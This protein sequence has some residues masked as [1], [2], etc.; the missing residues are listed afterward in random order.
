[1][2][3]LFFDPEITTPKRQNI[4]QLKDEIT[5]ENEVE[6]LKLVDQYQLQGKLPCECR[7]C[8]LDV[9]AIALNTLPS[10]Y[11]VAIHKDLYITPEQ[12]AAHR[13]AVE[14]AVLAACEK[15]KARPHH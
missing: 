12:Q 3:E 13:Q 5:N 7:D 10:H 2:S 14:Q 6:V 4:Y 9:T 11:T 15:V 8:L 1:M